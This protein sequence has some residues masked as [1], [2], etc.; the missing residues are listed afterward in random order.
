MS[1]AGEL[2]GNDQHLTCPSVKFTENSQ[3][4]LTSAEPRGDPAGRACAPLQRL[5]SYGLVNAQPPWLPELGDLRASPSDGSHKSSGA[6]TN[7]GIGFIVGLARRLEWIA[8]LFQ[9]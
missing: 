8:M 4:L 3:V 2:L 9:R 7:W 1:K 6:G 5:C